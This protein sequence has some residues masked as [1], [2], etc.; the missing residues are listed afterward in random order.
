MGIFY[1]LDWLSFGHFLFATHY[2]YN[3]QKHKVRNR[4]FS[5]LFFK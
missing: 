5:Q 3:V 2:I 1:F 4:G